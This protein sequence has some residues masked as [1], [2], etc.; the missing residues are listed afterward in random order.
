MAEENEAVEEE[1]PK[2]GKKG[3][4]VPLV[5]LLVALGLGLGVY[6]FIIL[7]KLPVEGE[8]E[9]S[10]EPEDTIPLMPVNL[11]FEMSTVNLMREGDQAAGVLLYQVSFECANQETFDLIQMFQ[12]RFVDMV[13]NIHASRTRDE[14]DDILQFKISAQRQIKQKANAIL[15]QLL[16]EDYAG[17]DLEVTGVFHGSCM[18]H[19]S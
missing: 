2:S 18:A 15:Q 10:A 9:T 16:P 14:V 1:T 3:I 19:D 17:A 6:K 11:D 7:P 13:N 4:I 12:P 5:L 8:M